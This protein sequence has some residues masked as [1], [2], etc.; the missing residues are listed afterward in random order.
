MSGLLAPPPVTKLPKTLPRSSRYYTI[1]TNPRNVF[2]VR[3]EEDSPTLMVGF[4][5]YDD[6]HLM[7]CMLET[8][9]LINDE[10]P[11]AKLVTDFNLPSAE[12][13][14]TDLRHLFLLHND[15]ENLVAWCTINFLDFLA[16]DDILENASGRYTWDTTTYKPEP[17]LQMCQERFEYLYDQF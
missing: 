7:A 5:N 8:Y 9:Y 6:A 14:V 16:V 2:G 10:L 17:D 3:L 11:L 1:H 15:T 13:S 12:E 4:R